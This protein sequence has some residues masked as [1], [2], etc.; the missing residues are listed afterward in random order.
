MLNKKQA[1]HSN[2]QPIELTGI[3]D[4]TYWSDLL[5]K[6]VSPV[7]FNLA[8]GTLRTKYANWKKQPGYILKSRNR[9]LILKQLDVQWRVLLHGLHLPDDESSEGQQRKQLRTCVVERNQQC[10]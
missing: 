2:D 1:A 6:M 5:Y 3:Q 7:V 10:G 9:L 8:A 4:R